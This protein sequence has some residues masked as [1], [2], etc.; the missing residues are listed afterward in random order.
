MAVRRSWGSAILLVL[1]TVVTLPVEAGSIVRGVT[2]DLLSKY[3][4]PSDAEFQCLDGRGSLPASRINDEYCDCTDGS[5][6]PGECSDGTVTDT[7][8]LDIKA[9]QAQ[10]LLCIAA[11][12][13]S[14][15]CSPLRPHP[16]R[17]LRLPKRV[18]LLCQRGIRAE[19]A[20]S[21]IRRR[22]RLW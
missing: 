18:L 19:D 11:S 17:H 21:C 20:Q 3:N 8:F 22:R 14:S 6:E 13:P 12:T 5:D 10:H 1:A 2:P 9:S 15:P 16:C 4:I 7:D